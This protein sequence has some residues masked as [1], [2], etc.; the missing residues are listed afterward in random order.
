MRQQ[1]S[2]LRLEQGGCGSAPGQL[3]EAEENGLSSPRA[4]EGNAGSQGTAL[5]HV[6]R[7]PSSWKTGAQGP[8]LSRR[9]L[10]MDLRG[11]SSGRVSWSSKARRASL[12]PALLL[13]CDPWLCEHPL[14]ALHVPPATEGQGGRRAA[15]T[16]PTA[17]R[18]GT[19]APSKQRIVCRGWHG[20]YRPLG[21]PREQHD[22]IQAL[23]ILCWTAWAHI[24]RGDPGSGW[25]RSL[26]LGWQQEKDFAGRLIW[27]QASW[28][29]PEV[30]Q[31][32]LGMKVAGAWVP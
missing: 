14:W 1:E 21:V 9:M 4:R 29:G 11:C 31:E 6:A 3:S 19:R 18:A 2:P 10:A 24:C 7:G 8:F 15:P 16:P 32:G 28:A 25:K 27:G 20:R 17:V 23:R 13:L 12:T 22:S 5:L 30:W 26:E